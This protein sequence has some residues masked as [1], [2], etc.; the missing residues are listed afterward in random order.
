MY[1]YCSTFCYIQDPLPQSNL[2]D[3]RRLFIKRR[4]TRPSFSCSIKDCD[5][6][7]KTEG[8]KCRR[9]K[10][11]D[12]Q[13]QWKE[14]WKA[15][16]LGELDEIT[17]EGWVRIRR[18]LRNL[19][20]GR[21]TW[22]NIREKLAS[23]KKLTE[24]EQDSI[25]RWK[26][27]CEKGKGDKTWGGGGKKIWGGIVEKLKS[28]KQL[29]E[30]EQDSIQRWKDGCEKGTKTWDD[31]LEKL[32]SGKQLTD[33]EKDSIQ[34]WKEGSEDGKKTWTGIHEKL[35]SGE[36]L[37]DEQKDSIV[38]WKEGVEKGRGAWA[39]V[40]KKLK[41]G[42]K[43]TDEQK[44][45]IKRQKAGANAGGHAYKEKKD[46]E[47]GRISNTPFIC[48][49]CKKEGVVTYKELPMGEKHESGLQKG[50]PKIGNAEP[51]SCCPGCRSRTGRRKSH[52]HWT[53][54]KKN[55]VEIVKKGGIPERIERDL[56]MCERE[57]CVSVP[58]RKKLCYTH[59]GY[60]RQRKSKSK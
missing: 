4:R 31:I 51:R 52:Q 60:K 17:P 55:E 58:Y 12:K 59:L 54:V 38:R 40:H 33:E 30:D 7:A 13:K 57:G 3:D 14:D 39:G 2:T 48:L 19:D 32:K 6:V 26:D 44:D 15:W 36:K 22:A 35:K 53:V 25:Q 37:T 16:R 29:T 45:S 56:I 34:R 11:W 41:S 20:K 46:K 1:F 21:K 43:L 27:G 50:L 49:Y 8:E 23:G 42:E 5:G 18:A 24:D 9:C 28:G 47:A 10:W